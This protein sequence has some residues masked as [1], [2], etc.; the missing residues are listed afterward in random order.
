MRIHVNTKEGKLSIPLPTALVFNDLTARLCASAA[1]QEHGLLMK[2]EAF[3]QLF[4]ALRE[5]GE[6]LGDTPFV[7]VDSANGEHVTITL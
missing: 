3:V 6:L 2:E 5:A 1:Q 7:E 4:A